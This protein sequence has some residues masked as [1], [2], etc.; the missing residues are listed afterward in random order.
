[1]P[2]ESFTFFSPE[3]AE[4]SEGERIYFATELIK[5]FGE[6]DVLV[7]DICLLR[8]NTVAGWDGVITMKNGSL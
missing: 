6:R 8:V 7:E 1:M 4:H 2:S 3:R 5:R